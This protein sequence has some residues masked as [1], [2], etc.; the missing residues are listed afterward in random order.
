MVMMKILLLGDHKVG[1]T[2]LKVKFMGKGFSSKYF[3]MQESFTVKTLQ[4]G[5]KEAKFQIYEMP[6]S[7]KFQSTRSLRFAGSHGVI[8]LFDVTQAETLHNL[9][10]FWLEEMRKFIND[11]SV[12][13]V[14]LG[15]KIDLRDN[16]NTS[17]INQDTGKQFANTIST[18]YYGKPN[19]INYFETSEKAGNNI[20]IA[21]SVLG[22]KIIEQN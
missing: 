22:K 19:E 6:V 1:K 8:L 11:G 17:H 5:D 10:S 16:R 13:T 20:E 18:N 3:Q 15:N 7:E 14:L 2:T 9:Q 4:L 12:P 21:L